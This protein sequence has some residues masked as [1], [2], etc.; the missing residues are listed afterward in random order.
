MNKGALAAVIDDD[1]SSRESLPDFLR[2]LGF[3][4]VAFTSAEEFLKSDVLTETQCLI[5]DV[6][7]P[8]MSGPDLQS[9]LSR[10]E[11][12]IPIIFMTAHFDQ[13]LR[14]DLIARGAV[15]CL[16][17]PLNDRELLSALNRAA[18]TA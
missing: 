6:S 11:L 17:K 8:A 7:M 14:A 10:R 4:A 15:D 1:V 9:E 13:Q 3:K 5:L 2:A 18:G 16:F 12:S